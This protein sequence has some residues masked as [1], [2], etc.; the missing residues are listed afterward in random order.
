MAGHNIE[1][2]ST[3]TYASWLN[4]IESHFAAAQEVRHQ[5]DR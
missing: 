5:R 2:V 4:A 1:P 3:P